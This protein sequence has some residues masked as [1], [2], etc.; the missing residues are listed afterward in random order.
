MKKDIILKDITKSAIREI[1]KYILHLDIEDFE[2]LDIEFSKIEAKEVDI[3][4]KADKKIIHVEFQSTNDLNMI[5]RMLRYYTEIQSRFKTYDIYQY[6]IYI[7]KANLRMKNILDKQNIKY[8]YEIIDIKKLD[9]GE[10]LSINKAEAL[11]MAILCDFKGRDE[12]I[13]IK[14]IL[15][16]LL[17][18]SSSKNEFKRNLL[19]LEELSTSRDLKKIIKE[20]EMGLMHTRWE[21]LPS[22]EIGL[23]KGIEDGMKKGIEKGIEKGKEEGFLKGKLEAAKLMLKE[24]NLK[25]EDVA[26]KLDIPFDIL[27]KHI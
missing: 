14:E 13:V 26:K 17:T 25:A 27:L 22:Y 18:L 24:F 3:L 2:F 11:I 19:M 21:D 1:F 16:K 5:Y 9:C 15:S 12:K 20:E 10:F 4:V 8:G 23:E 7:G 6:V